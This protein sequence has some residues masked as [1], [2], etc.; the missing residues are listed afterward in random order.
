[1]KKWMPFENSFQVLVILAGFFLLL[2]FLII[3]DGDYACLDYY[4]VLNICKFMVGFTFFIEE[5]GT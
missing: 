2:V 1:M 5:T 3:L 4:T